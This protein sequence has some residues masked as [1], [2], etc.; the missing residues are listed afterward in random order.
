MGLILFIGLVM[1]T[2]AAVISY[3]VYSAS[4]D[5]NYCTI[6]MKLAKTQAA[7]LDKIQVQKITEKTME[8]YHNIY[9]ETKK[10]SN[11]VLTAKQEKE[12]YYAKYQEIIDSKEYQSILAKLQE[13]RMVNQ[14]LSISICYIDT[15]A[16]KIVYIADGADLGKAHLIGDYNAIDDREDKLVKQGIYDFPAYITSDKNNSRIC[17]ASSGLYNEEGEIIA[18]IFVD[19]VMDT[20]KQDRQSFLI[21]LCLILSL[22]TFLMVG[23]FSYIIHYMVIAPIK[24]L[25]KAVDSF[26]TNRKRRRKQKNLSAISNLQIKTGDEIEVLANAFQKMESEINTYID[27]ITM[28]TAEKERMGAELNV[29]TQI[30]ADMLPNIF[31]AYP[32]YDEF[33]IYA[34]MTPAKEVGGDFYDFYMLDETHIAVVIADVSGK[35]VPA[36]LFMVIAK[37]LIKNHAQAGEEPKEIFTNVN[38]QL[39]ESNEVG[40]F[41]TGW[42]GILDIVTGHMLY[43]NAGHNYPVLI[44]K[45]Q[46]VQWIKSK[47]CFV[48]A[49]LEGIQYRQ[50]ELQFQEGEALYLYTDGVTETMNLSGEFFGEKRLEEILSQKESQGKHPKELLDKIAWELKQFSG[51]AQQ[52]DDIT[53][54]ALYWYGKK[55]GGSC[56][57]VQKVPAQISYFAEI[58]DFIIKQLEEVGSSQKIQT[59]ILIAVEEIFVNIASYAYENGEGEVEV[60]TCFSS[61]GQGKGEFRILIEDNGIP[62]NP[63]EYQNPDITLSAEERQI[64][65]LGIFI[66]KRNMDDVQYEYREGKNC[67]LMR[68]KIYP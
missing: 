14:V 30:Q 68:K 28:I 41:V 38:N 33:D 13:I 67:L 34:S 57:E 49:G 43:V 48:L 62:Y 65:G 46:T 51:E 15:T 45:D 6:A 23:I 8:I 64:G 50:N 47:P 35:G 32:E 31:P 19:I 66:V 60:K 27:N 16:N 54:L 10:T 17:S 36:A 3:K 44:C 5:K 61:N 29:A 37:T 9:K 25:S 24:N 21:K 12:D 55:E 2:S 4:I 63:L 42:L 56:W 7:A 22:D 53:M 39:N 26:I 11:F 58:N 52:A 59:Q 1:T 20:V 18:N 40:M